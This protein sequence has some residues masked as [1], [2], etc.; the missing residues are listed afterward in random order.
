MADRQSR[1]VRSACLRSRGVEILERAIRS[2]LCID[3][4]KVKPT[5]LAQAELLGVSPRTLDKILAGERVDR[6]TLLVAFKA[7]ELDFDEELC[8]PQDFQETDNKSP[9]KTQ[10]NLWLSGFVL[11]VATSVLVYVFVLNNKPNRDSWSSHFEAA[12]TTGTNE[13]HRGNYVI[14]EQK[15]VEAEELARSHRD[16]G[17]MASAL[18][19]RADISILRGELLQAEEQLLEALSLRK[20]LRNNGNNAGLHQALGDVYIRQD[21]L[22]LAKKHLG[23]ALDDFSKLE[24]TTGIAMVRAD[25]S[26]LAVESGDGV[27]A[28]NQI[29]IAEAT[30]KTTENLDILTDIRGRKAMAMIEMGRVADARSL[31]AQCMEYWSKKKHERWIALTL[32]QCG[33][34]E[35]SVLNH[36]RAMEYFSASLAMYQATGDIYR[37]REVK[38]ELEYTRLAMAINMN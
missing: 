20:S 32:F 19:M 36:H 7:V 10:R 34:L 6:S 29:L 25:L 12:L 8:L 37:Q 23:L 22:L 9:D 13:Y 18:R 33:K 4:P 28:L 15:I 30:A 5:R 27:G 16:A 14:A 35:S 26:T 11:V 3:N 17:H 21:K 2:K 24:D 31:L 38:N 1:R